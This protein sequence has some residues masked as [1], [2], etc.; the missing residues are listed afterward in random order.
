MHRNSIDEDLT[1]IL[2]LKYY[3]ID[4]RNYTIKQYVQN[5]HS[6]GLLRDVPVFQGN[7]SILS[8]ICIES[9]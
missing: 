3:N 6:L 5:I 8:L 1:I 4:Y 2:F 7:N 9:L